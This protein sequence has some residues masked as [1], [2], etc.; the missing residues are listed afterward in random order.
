MHIP[1]PWPWLT[2]G[3]ALATGL[4]AGGCSSLDTRPAPAATTMTGEWRV[5]PAASDDFDRK[6][7]AL[8]QQFHRREQPRPPFQGQPAAG[9]GGGGAAQIDPLMMPLEDPEKLHTRLA[10]DL[11]PSAALRIALLDDGVE[12]TRDSEPTRQYRPGQTVSRIDSSGAA[13]VSCGWDQGAFV[14]RAKYTNHGGRSWRLQHDAASDT[15]RVTFSASNPQYGQIE[16]HTL[17]RRA[18]G[19]AP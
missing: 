18:P 14:V 7:T 17:Y 4:I 10:D 13:S 15:L 19:A 2:C 9:G 8:L 6:L 1:T 16:V 11:R 12:I 3:A 5:D